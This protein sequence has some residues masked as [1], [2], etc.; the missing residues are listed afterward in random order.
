[1]RLRV[2]LPDV[3]LGCPPEVFGQI[4]RNLVG[5]AL[6]YR[7]AERRCRVEITGTAGLRSLTLAVEDNGI[8][9][10]GRAVRRAFEPFFRGS[11]HRPGHGL[12]LAIVDR[13]VRALGG[14]IALT[15]RLGVGT[16]VEVRWLPRTA[17]LPDVENVARL[18][19]VKKPGDGPSRS[20][21]SAG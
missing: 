3:H 13:Y 10:D 17:A 2:E 11:T 4:V 15:S 20:V 5:N 18:V 19:S 14:S 7:S 16:R 1:M 12:G 9:M 21:R 8:G 6:K